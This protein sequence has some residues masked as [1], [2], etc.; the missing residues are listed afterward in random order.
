MPNDVERAEE[1]KRAVLALC[2]GYGFSVSHEDGHGAFIIVPLD[3]FHERWFGDA[4]IELERKEPD[5]EAVRRSPF[6]RS[7][8]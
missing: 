7:I 3:D 1:F 6:T 8:R 4:R 5:L 2:R